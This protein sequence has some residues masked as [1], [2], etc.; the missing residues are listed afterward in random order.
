MLGIKLSEI[1]TFLAVAE[2]GS[3]N[4]AARRLHLTQPAVTRQIQRLEAELGLILLDRRSKP[5]TL[6]AAGRDAMEHCRRVLSAVEDLKA[7]GMAEGATAGRLRLGFAHG[8]V[9]LA[10]TRPIDE[11]RAAFPLVSLQ[12]GSGWTGE[13]IDQVRDG[14]LDAAVVLI[15][16]NEHPPQDIEGVR[17]GSEPVWIV[18]SA[19][20]ETS[21]GPIAPEELARA[22]WV[23]NPEGCGYHM[24]VQ[25]LLDRMGARLEVA[26]EV[27]GPDIQLS[28]IARGVGFG[29]VPARRVMQSAQAGELRRIEVRGLDL[30]LAVWVLRS[31]LAGRLTPAI[32]H[33]AGSLATLWAPAPAPAA[34]VAAV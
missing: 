24:V 25:R 28:L 19:R 32:D 34:A 10:V 22:S 7:M 16:P 9:D 18:G 21:S 6:T 29:L 5:P 23:L 14:R 17:V 33:L 4:G 30:S 27:L 20:D 26:A 15:D 31:S 2:A 11:L 13:L 12:I 1:E 3:I 8:V